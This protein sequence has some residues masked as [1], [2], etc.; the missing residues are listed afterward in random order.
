MTRGDVI[1]CIFIFLIAICSGVYLGTIIQEQQV[2]MRGTNCIEY[3]LIGERP[4][5]VEACMKWER[6][7]EQLNKVMK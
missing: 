2:T 4:N 3:G 1:F 6:A 5:R 7:K